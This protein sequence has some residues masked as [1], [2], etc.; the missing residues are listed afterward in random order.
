MSLILSREKIKKKMKELELDAA[1]TFQIAL[2]NCDDTIVGRCERYSLAH[3][4]FN[5]R[6]LWIFVVLGV[7]F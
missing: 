5:Q 2:F 4:K 1:A 7:F 3:A 6:T